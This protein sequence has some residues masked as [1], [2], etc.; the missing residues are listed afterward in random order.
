[1]FT[2]KA[3]SYRNIQ[4]GWKVIQY[5]IDFESVYYDNAKTQARLK[6]AH[7]MNASQRGTR[8]SPKLKFNMQLQ[9]IVAE[10]ACQYYLESILKKHQLDKIWK[11]L[12]YDEVRMDEFKSP[13]GE[14]DLKLVH[15]TQSKKHFT[16]ESRS[17]ITHNRS[18]ENG[19][20]QYDIIGTYSSIAKSK[21]SLS[22]IYLRPLY[23]YADYQQKN[24]SKLDFETH[25]E[26]GKIQLY[27]VAGCTG[28]V[29]QQEGKMKSM[30]Q[31][32]SQ[33]LT[34]PILKVEDAVDFAFTLK[35]ILTEH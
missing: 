22:D 28:E 1:M 29:M 12:R 32:Q 9:G 17:S 15:R 23:A 33:Y 5:N 16:I 26:K 31:G 6:A 24:Y 21:E 11:V 18:F 14:F 10:M 4:Q 27:L 25:L 19:L 20:R 3:L 30:R 35:Q 13:E 34:I 7:T 8:R 2:P